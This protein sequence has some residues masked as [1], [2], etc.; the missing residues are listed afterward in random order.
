VIRVT[1]VIYTAEGAWHVHAHWL[2]ISRNSIPRDRAVKIAGQLRDRWINAATLRG[3]DAR[4]TGQD[5]RLVPVRDIPRVV[6]YLTKDHAGHLY[7]GTERGMGNLLAEWYAGDADSAALFLELE[8]A[9]HGRRWRSVS[10][11]F[12]ATS[13]PAGPTPA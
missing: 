2:L 1:E 12:R 13:H 10:G 5:I 9:A 8:R 4:P 3:I 11:I 6:G 7:E